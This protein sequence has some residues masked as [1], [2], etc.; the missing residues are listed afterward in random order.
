MCEGRLGVKM[1][2]GR[3]GGGY[4]KL[5]SNTALSPPEKNKKIK[6]SETERGPERLWKTNR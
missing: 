1:G 5:V 6:K 4:G 2:G 3:G